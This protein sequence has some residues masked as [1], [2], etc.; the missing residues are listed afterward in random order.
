MKLDDELKAAVT[1]FDNVLRDNVL[2]TTVDFDGEHAFETVEVGDK[3][4]GIHIEA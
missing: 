1:A 4:I 3:S 2:V